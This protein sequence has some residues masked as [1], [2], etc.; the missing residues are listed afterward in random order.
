MHEQKALREKQNFSDSLREAKTITQ[1]CKRRTV[2]K[3]TGE[4]ALLGRVET[5]EYSKK[6]IAR[7]AF[8]SQGQKAPETPGPEGHLF[9][10]T[11]CRS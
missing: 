1:T 6:S 8:R 5:R 3:M 11:L 2:R 7:R 4:I 9:K 10:R